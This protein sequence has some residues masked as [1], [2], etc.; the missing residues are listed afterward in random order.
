M[1]GRESS[2]E[3]GIQSVRAL[4]GGYCLGPEK[5]LAPSCW[6][7]WHHPQQETVLIYRPEPRQAKLAPVPNLNLQ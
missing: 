6:L 7:D 1:A 3:L 4:E 5:C 2:S